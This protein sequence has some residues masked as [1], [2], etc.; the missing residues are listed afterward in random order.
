MIKAGHLG[1]WGWKNTR[2]LKETTYHICSI[3]TTASQCNSKH[4]DHISVHNAIDRLRRPLGF[5][6][7]N[8]SDAGGKAGASQEDHVAPTTTTAKKASDRYGVE[9][10]LHSREE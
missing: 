5:E 2:K 9:I 10:F 7:R 1:G 6:Y 8:P 4:D 3:R